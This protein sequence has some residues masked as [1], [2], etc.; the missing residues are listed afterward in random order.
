M[1][2]QNCA[3]LATALILAGLLAA[4]G[5]NYGRTAA[6][7][8]HSRL[9]FEQAA[10]QV[11]EQGS[12]QGVEYPKGVQAIQF[13]NGSDGRETTV[14]FLCGAGGCGGGTRYWGVNYVVNDLPVGFQA[15]QTE[16][17][18]KEGSGTRFYEA[19]GNNTCYVE[20]LEKGWYYY[21]MEF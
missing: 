11:L 7:F 21:E 13:W 19:E 1:R 17:W 12:T 16:Y 20:R 6:V 5:R 2:R 14:E 3:A 18:N 4:C 15:F 9:Q 10:R 8:A